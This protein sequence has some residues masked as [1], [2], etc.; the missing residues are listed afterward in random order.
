[1]QL[2]QWICGNDDGTIDVALLPSW[3][4][5]VPATTWRMQSMPNKNPLDVD[6]SEIANCHIT[7]RRACLVS[8]HLPFALAAAGLDETSTST[9]TNMPTNMPLPAPWSG[10]ELRLRLDVSSLTPA[11]QTSAVGRV[12]L[13]AEFLRCCADLIASA[14]LS[15]VC[16]RPHDEEGV[17]RIALGLVGGRSLTDVADLFLLLHTA[18]SLAAQARGLV[19]LTLEITSL[20]LLLQHTEKFILPVDGALY[21]RI[22]PFYELCT[23]A[24]G[25]L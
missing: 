15:L 4:E 12:G 5:S 2:V 22:Q 25:D 11:G 9:P 10:L 1:M 17:W 23:K 20:P 3:A 24:K 21:R 8:S 6:A 16:L 14:G 13:F 7:R 19:L 18:V